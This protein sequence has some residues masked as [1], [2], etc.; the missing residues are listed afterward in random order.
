[1]NPVSH[2]K[3][4]PFEKSPK[5]AYETNHEIFLLISLVNHPNTFKENKCLLS[6]QKGYEMMHLKKTHSELCAL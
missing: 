5:F 2:K 4:L 6:L 3:V 1:M